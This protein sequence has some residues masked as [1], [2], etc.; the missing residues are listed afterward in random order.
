MVHNEWAIVILY[1]LYKCNVSFRCS[2][3]WLKPWKRFDE[4]PLYKSGIDCFQQGIKSE[5]L[6]LNITHI[7]ARRPSV[8]DGNR[9]SGP[10][11]RVNFETNL[12][13]GAYVGKD[14]GQLWSEHFL[15]MLHYFSHINSFLIIYIDSNKINCTIQ[16][17]KRVDHLSNECISI[18]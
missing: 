13:V 18:Q 11:F 15:R 1:N 2:M 9:Y 17:D 14:S 4:A 3:I 6:D 5:G 7:L 8:I 12:K 16:Q 10:E